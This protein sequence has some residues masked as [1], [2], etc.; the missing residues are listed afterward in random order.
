LLSELKSGGEADALL[1][2]WLGK[3]KSP[4]LWATGALRTEGGIGVHLGGGIAV[5]PL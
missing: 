3:M 5:F 4:G 2:A 1:D